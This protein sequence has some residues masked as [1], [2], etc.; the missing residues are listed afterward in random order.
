M[1]WYTGLV[2]LLICFVAPLSILADEQTDSSQDNQAAE[3]AAEG[4]D[5]EGTDDEESK[6]DAAEEEAAEEEPTLT[7]G[8]KAP[9]LAVEHW[10]QDGEGKFKPVTDFEKG[11]VYV[12]EFWATWCG[13]CLASM[14]HLSE[15]QQKH[16][17][18]GVRIVSI[19]DEDLETVKTFLE[20]EVKGETDKTY[21]DITKHYSLT[22]DPDG[23]SQKDYML[24]AKQN[25]I[26]TAFIVG[27]DGHID[28]IGH[29]MQMDE[30]LEKVVDGTWDRLAF[31]NEF[32]A[33]QRI[34]TIIQK[35]VSRLRAGETDDALKLIDDELA[36]MS[37]GPA[38]SQFKQLKLRLLLQLEKPAAELFR[39]L[40]KEN[41]DK[42][43]TLNDLAWLVFQLAEADQA[44]GKELVPDAIKAAEMAVR[45]S[46]GELKGMLLDTLARLHDHQGNLDKALELQRQAAELAPQADIKEFLEK[47]EAKKSGQ[48]KDADK[49]ESD[50]KP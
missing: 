28:W 8:S 20:R 2:V 40:V 30:P 35:V 39:E 5:K 33:Q 50:D 7:I 29:P 36:K 18:R 42:A 10:V 21:N 24:A 22:T 15:L 23:S 19:S 1:R 11:K 34:A 44:G 31:Q 38:K 41:K 43:N 45:Q 4:A 26:P 14:P 12:V 27:K 16:A 32:K 37:D 48:D 47:L 17:D 6:K 13:P 3:Q 49:E 46:E 25:G 9:A